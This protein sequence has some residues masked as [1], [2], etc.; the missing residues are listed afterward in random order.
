[1][2]LFDFSL[3]RE[4]GVPESVVDSIAAFAKETPPIDSSL[5]LKHQFYDWK[6]P[7]TNWAGY[8]ARSPSLLPM[9]LEILSKVKGFAVPSQY[10]ITVSDEDADG[11]PELFQAAV[12]PND[13]NQHLF[14]YQQIEEVEN[15][16]ACYEFCG[17]ELKKT[18]KDI[19]VSSWMNK[20]GNTEQATDLDLWKQ[21]CWQ[22]LTR[23]DGRVP[24]IACEIPVEL[25]DVMRADP[26]GNI[27]SITAED[28]SICGIRVA[29]LFPT[30]K[31]G[32]TRL[33]NLA[34]F[35][36]HAARIK[37]DRVLASILITDGHNP[38][39][40]GLSDS[41]LG[42]L[43]SVRSRL[44][45]QLQGTAAFKSILSALLN[46]AWHRGDPREIYHPK[47][48]LLHST[49]PASLFVALMSAFHSATAP[50]VA[51]FHLGMLVGLP[52]EPVPAGSSDEWPVP[53]PLTLVHSSYSQLL[54][55]GRYLSLPA[56]QALP[57]LPSSLTFTNSTS[58][59]ISPSVKL[60]PGP[61]NQSQGKNKSLS[62]SSAGR[63]SRRRMKDDALTSTEPVPVDEG[64]K[65]EVKEKDDSNTTPGSNV[66]PALRNQMRDESRLSSKGEFDP[67][68]SSSLTFD[69]LRS[70]HKWM[71]TKFAYQPPKAP[72]SNFWMPD[73]DDYQKWRAGGASVPI[74]DTRRDTH[75]AMVIDSFTNDLYRYRDINDKLQL[76][77]AT[78]G[79]VVSKALG[80][81]NPCVS[82]EA[83][84]S[85]ETYSGFSREHE[86][87]QAVMAARPYGPG[88]FPGC[89]VPPPPPPPSHYTLVDLESGESYML[90]RGPAH[91]PQLSGRQE[92]LERRRD[93]LIFELFPDPMSDLQ[94][95]LD[96][97]Y[98]QKV[99]DS[100]K[101]KMQRE[102]DWQ[103]EC[104][105]RE[106]ERLLEAQRQTILEMETR[107]EI[108]VAATAAAEAAAEAFRS[109][110]RASSFVGGHQRTR[111]STNTDFVQQSFTRQ[112]LDFHSLLPLP[113]AS[114]PS[115]PPFSP[116]LPPPVPVIIAAPQASDIPPPP[117]PPPASAG[118]PASPFKPLVG[119]GLSLKAMM[120]GSPSNPP[121]PPL[122]PPQDQHLEMMAEAQL[123]AARSEEAAN[124]AALETLGR[125]QHSSLSL[126]SRNV[127]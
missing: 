34:A 38:L 1:M 17:F 10:P 58:S 57:P 93:P 108:E 61:M 127:L 107:K 40:C 88:E 64:K 25:Q 32:R 7:A 26:F 41:M 71:T 5:L 97:D 67:L 12:N 69:Q 30:E 79:Y 103:L 11:F 53:P 48:G 22:L 13:P 74:Q 116:P 49:P 28:K 4:R 68:P 50:L 15:G 120:F 9:H 117:P 76:H 54:D 27:V 91:H 2:D 42:D 84:R 119:M 8:R 14:L 46:T 18:E 43:W 102:M 29:H 70:Q 109:V 106:K 66:H 39:S 83:L 81:T 56:L 24:P 55:I 113:S 104:L 118:Q 62:S 115:A 124:Q 20:G 111:S 3:L 36:W 105:E 37:G 63:P 95:F 126:A 33:S 35:H 16:G 90:Q 101:L 110:S 99:L 92:M 23:S 75:Q 100:E 125:S 89:S 121:P 60:D 6:P 86:R 73:Q 96:F 112:S 72:V 98:N 80:L 31:G 123:L 44:P 65:E 21:E 51:G 52:H 59:L 77:K 82:N 45:D 94:R 19:M 85:P 122:P 78:G 114:Y 47:T 87:W